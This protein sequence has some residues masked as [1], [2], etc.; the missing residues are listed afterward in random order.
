[1]LLSTLS[2]PAPPPPKTPKK[3]KKEKGKVKGGKSLP[4][5]GIAWDELDHAIGGP[6]L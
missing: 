5:H 1:M 3:K 2:G 4:Y 6:P